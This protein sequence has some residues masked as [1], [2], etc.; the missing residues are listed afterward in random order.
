MAAPTSTFLI[1]PSGTPQRVPLDQADDLQESGWVPASASQVDDVKKQEKFGSG[2]EQAKT[3]L[4]GAAQSLTLGGSTDLERTLGVQGRD[5]KAREDVNPSL[6]TAGEVVGA[7][8]PAAVSGG[9]SLLEGAAAAGVKGAAGLAEASAPS[10]INSLGEGAAG[11]VKSA[12]PEATTTLGKI[13]VKGA[14]GLAQG[15]TEGGLYGVQ[16]VVHEDGLGD[17]NLTAQSAME[18]IGLS[19]LMGG[20]VGGVLH[21][22]GGALSE[23]AGKVKASELGDKLSTWLGDFEGERGIKAAGGIQSDITKATKRVG[24]DELLKISRE[25]RDLGILDTF[26]TP[27]SALEKSQGVM[28]SAGA[29]MGE[30]LDSA[31]AAG[32]KPRTIEEITDRVRRE[33]LA[34][35]EANPLEKGTASQLKTILDDYADKF[36]VGEQAGKLGAEGADAVFGASKFGFKDL[37]EIRKQLSEK[38]YGL[39]GVADPN[40]TA[41]KS[42]LHDFRS[43]VSDEINQGMDKAG[44]D[45]RPW[46]QA[47]REYQVGATMSNFAEKGLARAHG[48]NLIPATTLI[49]GLA[50]AVT[51]GVPGGTLLGAGAYAA[52]RYGSSVLGAG[53][54]GVRNFLDKE[55]A[56]A[57]ADTTAD[58]I[59]AQRR[60]GAD[61][62]AQ[63]A[64]RQ[65]ETVAALSHL[66]KTNQTVRQRIADATKAI[67]TGAPKA[68]RSASAAG[69]ADHLH[70]VQQ[71]IERVT[72]LAANPDM[73]QQH[74]EQHAESMHEHA[75]QTAQGMSVAQSRA[76]TF[77]ASKAPQQ[78]KLGPLGPTLELSQ[79]QKWQF[80]RYYEAVDRPTR[81]LEHAKAGTLTPMDVEAVQAVYPELY[82]HMQQEAFEQISEH[83]GVIPYRNR[84]SLSLL[85]GQSMDGTTSQPSISANQAIYQMPSAKGPQDQT[86]PAATGKSTQTGLSKL[87]TSGRA[88]LPGQASDSR[89]DN[90]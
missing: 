42:A 5:I 34:P 37:H 36:H 54:R 55:G 21:G 68:A 56:S 17:P 81:I 46:K 65:P 73:L 79:A 33:T 90:G 85:M 2:V 64:V 30:V 11:L 49:S 40:A 88:M 32:A 76:V 25:A 35:L 78:P 52:K 63:E 7:L 51:H 19:A 69:I 27:A 22:G 26:T 14:A 87:K 74:L 72:Q 66:E 80:N 38:I 70:T 47:N 48:N 23:L 83:K 4:E 75:P 44:L 13:A 1:D 41:M 89:R 50:G 24:K 9:A 82:A 18:E 16:H 12:L 61:T 29:K 60:A 31:E 6:H 3:A 20:G 58:A 71:R 62:I 53:A 86:G 77:L 10:L 84:L 67:L 57:L 15:A 43:I 8:A 59:A 45:S 28:E 39:R